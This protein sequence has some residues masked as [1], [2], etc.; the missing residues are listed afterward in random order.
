MK[1]VLK[2]LFAVLAVAAFIPLAS[3]AQS[4][5]AA[6]TQPPKGKYTVLPPRLYSE[7]VMPRASSLA[8][9][10]ERFFHL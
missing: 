1:V 5:D 10:V 9:D 7:L 8:A 2:R 4:S 6:T 3:L